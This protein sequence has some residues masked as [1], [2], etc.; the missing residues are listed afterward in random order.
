MK[1]VLMAG[2]ERRFLCLSSGPLKAMRRI[3]DSGS[4]S[5]YLCNIEQHWLIAC[6]KIRAFGDLVAEEV[7]YI[8]SE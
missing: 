2:M 4:R 7:E 8:S 3:P 1:Q 5:Y 6:S